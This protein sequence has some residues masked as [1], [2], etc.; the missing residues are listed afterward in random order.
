[1]CEINNAAGFTTLEYDRDLTGKYFKAA[2]CLIHKPTSCDAQT[3]ANCTL[4]A[5]SKLH[6]VAPMTD[7]DAIGQ[8]ERAKATKYCPYKN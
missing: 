5:V 3:W 8:C 7:A 2:D 6:K 1:M 4:P